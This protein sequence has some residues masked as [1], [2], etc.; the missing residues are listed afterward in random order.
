MTDLMTDL[1]SICEAPGC[2]K[3]FG[4]ELDPN[5]VDHGDGMYKEQTYYKWYYDITTVDGDVR[6]DCVSALFPFPVGVSYAAYKD[7]CKSATV[8]NARFVEV[9]ET[10][11]YKE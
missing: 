2:T 10:I 7:F 9:K 3:A 4:H 6:R 5:D 8:T 1:P 11:L